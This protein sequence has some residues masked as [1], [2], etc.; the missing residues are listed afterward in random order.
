M[1]EK[2]SVYW[3]ILMII[4]LAVLSLYTFLIMTIWNKVIVKKFPKQQIETLDFWDALAISVFVSILSGPTIVNIY[5]VQAS[6][7]VRGRI[8]AL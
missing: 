3:I 8:A 1:A 7:S 2:D 6:P 4:G 5:S